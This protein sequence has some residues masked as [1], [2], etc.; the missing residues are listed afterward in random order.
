[1][2]GFGAQSFMAPLMGALLS[3]S[4]D[5]DL[6]NVSKGFGIID[7]RGWWNRSSQARVGQSSKKSKVDGHHQPK[8]RDL[9]SY[10]AVRQQ[11]L[12]LESTPEATAAVSAGADADADAHHDHDSKIVEDKE[13]A[14]LSME[15]MCSPLMMYDWM[16][17]V[18]STTQEVQQLN[19]DEHGAK[20]ATIDNEDGSMETTRPHNKARYLEQ[21]A[22]M[23]TLSCEA[24]LFVASFHESDHLGQANKQSTNDAASKYYHGTL[25]ITNLSCQDETMIIFAV[26]SSSRL[27]NY[28]EPSR[29]QSKTRLRGMEYVL[30]LDQCSLRPFVPNTQPK[31]D[32]FHQ[33][34]RP[35]DEPSEKKKG[36]PSNAAVP[37]IHPAFSSS[38]P[39]TWT[40]RRASQRN[41]EEE[42]STSRHHDDELHIIPFVLPLTYVHPQME[43]LRD[44]V[45]GLIRQ[46]GFSHAFLIGVGALA[47]G[48]A[49]IHIIVARRMLHCAN[50]TNAELSAVSKAPPS[51]FLSKTALIPHFEKHNVTRAKIVAFFSRKF[52]WLILLITSLN[53]IGPT[54]ECMGPLQLIRSALCRLMVHK[55][56]ISTTLA[57]SLVD[58]IKSLF[59]QGFTSKLLLTICCYD[60]HAA[61]GLC[62]Q[63][64][65]TFLFSLTESHCKVKEDP[66]MAPLLERENDTNTECTTH[67]T[68]KAC[69]G[70]DEEVQHD[71]AYH[72]E[73]AGDLVPEEEGV[74]DDECEVYKNGDGNS[75]GEEQLEL[76]QPEGFEME[77]DHDAKISI[78]NVKRKDDATPLP[79]IIVPAP[80]T[81]VE[82]EETEREQAS[83]GES[84]EEEPIDPRARAA[85]N[86]FIAEILAKSDKMC[87]RKN[88]LPAELVPS[89]PPTK[90]N[91]RRLPLARENRSSKNVISGQTITR[92]VVRSRTQ[93]LEQKFRGGG[94]GG[95]AAGSTKDTSASNITSAPNLINS[96]GI[97]TLEKS[98][99]SAFI[100]PPP[101]VQQ[102]QQTTAASNNK[103]RIIM[104]PVSAM[105]LTPVSPHDSHEDAFTCAAES[106]IM[107]DDG[108]HRD[109]RLSFLNEYWEE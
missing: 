97:R 6:D 23:G 53:V 85:P 60:C 50:E 20:K 42:S 57:T 75:G 108:A 96:P 83:A 21:N 5:F 74:D 80:P 51:S 73:I 38:L 52:K 44:R 4:G 16:L 1:M 18:S 61:G 41:G 109:E 17:A 7:G 26:P 86:S 40:W 92:N 82:N 19:H 89:S 105:A 37:A 62:T 48:I 29:K 107:D 79:P 63:D 15:T 70:E 72:A 34:Q 81:T 11:Y 64:V 68:S 55:G 43:Q 103:S 46:H 32:T 67:V 56:S 69:A 98:K 78:E 59:G 47:I 100:S 13:V 87:K 49:T 28:L 93:D 101:A 3:F 33:H 84:E 39:K 76:L 9:K 88:P 45:G 58:A 14:L 104:S 24:S 36:D 91:Q 2:R 102:P 35:F 71:L 66:A 95:A 10:G 22:I 12:L 77:T 30:Q 31:G 94:G 25:E 65:A 27:H 106:H 90:T 8:S 99:C 54:V